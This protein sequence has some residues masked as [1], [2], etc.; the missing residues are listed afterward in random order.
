MQYNTTQTESV[1]TM[2]TLQTKYQNMKS[3]AR[4]ERQ[5]QTGSAAGSSQSYS[6][7][8][9]NFCD[10]GGQ[11]KRNSSG[12]ETNTSIDPVTS[13]QLPSKR[14]RY[15]AKEVIEI[16]KLDIELRKLDIENKKLDIEIR[17]LAMKERQLG[18]P[19]LN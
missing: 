19:N 18:P 2:A 5:N 13:S 4:R 15:S 14:M 12:T 9:V 17:R 8:F 16:K 3:R 11:I 6:K 7:A 10:V 1:K